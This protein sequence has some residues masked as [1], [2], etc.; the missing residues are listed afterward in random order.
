MKSKM[1]LRKRKR[2]S[3][4]RKNNKTYYYKTRLVFTYN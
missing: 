3:K 2:K 1:K 4:L